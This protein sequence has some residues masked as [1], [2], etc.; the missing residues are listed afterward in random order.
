M[1]TAPPDF[2]GWVTAIEPGDGERVLGRIVVESQAGKIVRRLIV[3][4]T[5]DT[6]MYRRE[7]GAT[8]QAAF[9]SIAR[10]DQA[11]LWLTSSVPGSFP[12]EVTALQVVVEQPY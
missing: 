1:V 6:Q 10:Q 12:A 8:R 11:E 7:V 2:V 4:I 9:E 3:T 5:A